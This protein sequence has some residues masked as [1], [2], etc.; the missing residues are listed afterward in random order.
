MNILCLR[1][2]LV[3]V[4]LTGTVIGQDRSESP[5]PLAFSA[6]PTNCETNRARFDGLATYFRS[7]TNSKSGVLIAIARLGTGERSPKLN[8][9]RLY[10]VRATLI[11]DLKLREEE[12]V[13]AEGPRVNGFGRV[14]VYIGGKL[15]DTLLVNR[16]KALCADCCFPE[17]KRYSYPMQKKKQ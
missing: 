13:T 1:F 16:G 5:I 7:T 12:V 15:V 4:V 3:A 14:D 17:G 2:V 11:E 6:T 10:I 8:R 9:I